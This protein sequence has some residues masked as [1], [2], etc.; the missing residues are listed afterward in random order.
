MLI[1]RLVDVLE[2]FERGKPLGITEISEQTSL[3]KGTV[4]RIVTNLRRRGFLEQ[5]TGSKRYRLGPRLLSLSAVAASQNDL[6][7]RLLPQMIQLRDQIGETVLLSIRLDEQSHFTAYQVESFH[8]I[9]MSAQIGKPRPL[10]LGCGGKA[11]LAFR[12]VAERDRLLAGFTGSQTAAGEYRT[13]DSIR[14]DLES[15]RRVGYSK[16]TEELTPGATGVGVP[17]FDFAGD[18][19]ASLYI[20]GPLPRFSETAQG[21]AIRALESMARQSASAREAV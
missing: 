7:Q 19:I 12:P 1:D 5:K 16:S 20:A 4:H 17:I 13:S 3:A 11:I 8:S 21:E 2:C 15:I 10:F 14:T 6:V 9:R 18:A